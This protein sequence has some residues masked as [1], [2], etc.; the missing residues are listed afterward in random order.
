MW[1]DVILI[2]YS[3]SDRSSFAEAQ[4]LKITA[5]MKRRELRMD[6]VSFFEGIFK[7]KMLTKC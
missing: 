7:S 4:R 6:D 1:C 2:V 5:K 3:V